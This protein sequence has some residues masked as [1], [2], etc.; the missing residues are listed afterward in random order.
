[1]E[2]KAAHVSQDKKMKGAGCQPHNSDEIAMQTSLLNFFQKIKSNYSNAQAQDTASSCQEKAGPSS[3]KPS[4]AKKSA[5]DGK[6]SNQS[7]FV[8]TQIHF[9]MKPALFRLNLVITK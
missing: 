3:L 4:D 2:G 5:D 8:Q 7:S 9:P 6:V 1:M